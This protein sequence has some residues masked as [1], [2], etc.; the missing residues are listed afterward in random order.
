MC[1]GMATPILSRTYATAA[2]SSAAATATMLLSAALHRDAPWAGINAMTTVL[3]GGGRTPLRFQRKRSLLGL[4]ILVGG[5]TAMSAVY[6][7][8]LKRAPARRGLI[9][10]ALFALGGYAIDRWLLPNRVLRNF[11]RGMGPVGT[12]AKYA[13]LAIAAAAPK[14]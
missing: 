1:T 14:R 6:E 12:F 11:Q 2:A 4:G 8:A 13:A 10:G 7:V 5:L 9:S 3:P